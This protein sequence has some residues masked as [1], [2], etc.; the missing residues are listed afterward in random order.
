MIRRLLPPAL[1]FVLV[2]A[3]RVAPAQTRN[4]DPEAGSTTT[5]AARSADGRL[6][7]LAEPATGPVS[8]DGRLDEDVWR[9]ASPVTG[10]VQAEPND[11]EPATEQ[12]LVRVAFDASMLYIAAECRDSRAGTGLVYDIREDFLSTDQDTFEVIIDTFADRQNGYVFVTNREGARSDRQV[13]NEG[14]EINSS[15]DAVWLVETAESDEGWTVE[16]AIPFASLR[17]ERGMTD[18]W[19]INFSRRVRAKNEVDFWSPVPR[20]YNLA[21]V[22]LAGNLEGLGSVSPGRNLQLKPYALGRT[23]RPVGRDATFDPGAAVGL[24]AK[25]G[26]TPSLTLDL[27]AHPDFAQVEADELTVNLTQF[28]TFYQEKRDFFIENSGLFYVGDTARNNRVTT[29][30][31]PDEDLLL[32]HSRRIGLSSDGTPLQTLGGARLTGRVGETQLGLLTM[33]VDETGGL[34][35]TN[36]T[37]LRARRS[38]GSGSDVGAIVLSRATGDGNDFNRVYGAD[39]TLRFLGRIDWNT[40][41]VKTASP[42]VTDGQYAFRTSVNREGNFFHGKG[43]FMTLGEGFRDDIGY[44]R[45]TGVRKYFFDVGI[46]PRPVSWA[47][48]GIREWHPHAV[49]N[50]YTNLQ[51]ESIGRRLHTGSSFFFNSGAFI[52]VSINPEMERLDAPLRL[53]SKAAPI[54]PGDYAWNQYLIWFQS[55]ASRALSGSVRLTMGGLWSGTQRSVNTSVSLRPNHRFR[56]SISLNRTSADLG[57]PDGEF[58]SAVWTSRVNY[59]F[60]TNMFLDSLVQYDQDRRRLNANIR[61]NVMHHPLSDLFVVYNEQQFRDRPDLLPGRS[62]IVKFTQMMQF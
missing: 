19:G 33:Q 45:R 59:S 13:A 53:S 46:R 54:A 11:G 35:A 34:P 56:V 50:I 47:K 36:Y 10:F 51:G 48:R 24:D 26:L 60:T 49:W 38:F 2:T 27:T 25:F 30:P 14:R 52:E 29:T 57:G 17:F 22:S 28:S 9:R 37:V 7:V 15:W 55:D 4:G 40:Y 3:P 16:M 12:T 31:T 8:I 62:I 58:V 21:R 32:F 44:Y 23:V 20:A 43:G 61:F 1:A 41:A 5:N 18:L 42:G 6:L 39:M